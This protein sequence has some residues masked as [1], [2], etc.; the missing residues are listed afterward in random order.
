MKLTQSAIISVSFPPEICVCV[1]VC[2][3]ARERV[4]ACV[5]VCARGCVCV[6]AL[7]Q[8]SLLNIDEM[9]ASAVRK[10]VI[11]ENDIFTGTA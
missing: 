5:C 9:Y 4:C 10:C 1:C 7:R 8:H 3:C 2:V 11:N 6:C